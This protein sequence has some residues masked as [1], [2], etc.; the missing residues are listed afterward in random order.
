M[1]EI[2]V[3]GGGTGGHLFPAIAA[4]EE[5][6][7]RG[8]NVHLITDDRC[9]KYLKNHTHIKTHIINSS[10]FKEGII[11]KILAT[12]KV[13]VAF[14]KTASLFAHEK[15]KLVMTF[16]GYVAFAPLLCARMLGIPTILHEQNCFLGKVNKWF[17]WS[18]TK[19]LLTFK[20]TK[21]IP[22]ESSD[23]I[24]VSGNPVRSEVRAE[25]ST[26][27]AKKDFTT[28]PFKIAVIGGS[29]GAKVFSD[30]VPKAIEVALK[31]Q[32][33][34]K[35]SIVQQAKVED[36]EN[37]SNVYKKCDI[38]AKLSDF[39]YN[40]PEILANSHLVIARSGASTI[41]ELIALAQPAIFVPFPF[42]SEKHQHFNAEIIA[43]NSGGWWIDQDIITSEMLADKI[44]KLENDRTALQKAS[45]NLEA[46]KMDAVN[47]IANAAEKV[48]SDLKK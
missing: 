27:Y 45:K 3:V 17:A 14:I 7:R 20:E 36:I 11:G 8:H 9:A 41:A 12:F 25:I 47:I 37:I 21:N 30:L 15:P 28:S 42:A 40:I 38:D 24:I 22:L 31:K 1:K 4:A 39:F 5:L 43:K 10:G 6:I 29:Q 46:L 23:K 34:L 18:A 19:I 26:I 33:N 44:L 2:F 35:L 16:G 32:P 13:L 48:I